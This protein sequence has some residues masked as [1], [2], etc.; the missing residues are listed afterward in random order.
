MKILTKEEE[1]AH[2]KATL[3]GGLM[4]GAAGTGLGALGVYAASARYPAFRGL[5]LPFRAFLIAST[6]TFASIVAADSYSR[7]FEASKQP[8][9]DYADDQQ[10]L[11]DQLDANRTTKQKTMAWLQDNRY[12]IVLGSWVASI[13]LAMGIVGKN[14]YLTTQ[15]KLV[16]ARVYAQGFTLA[17]VIVSL[18]FEGGD[19]MKGSGRWETVKILDPNDPTHKNMIE[20]KIHHEKYAGED[21]WMDMVEAEEK[22][23]KEREAAVKEREAENEKKN[24][25]GKGK[26]KE[27]HH[28]KE[29]TEHLDKGNPEEA[30][31]KK[32]NAP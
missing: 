25:N 5:T 17:A 8:G 13:S 1:S 11:Q 2:Y 9:R 19:R 26:G 24:G 10:I 30:K 14:P 23:I 18:A 20:K 6:G 12:S 7:R 16:Q 27:T 15:Q 29:K 21:Q 32:V 3:T 31:D 4:G 28:K 22:R